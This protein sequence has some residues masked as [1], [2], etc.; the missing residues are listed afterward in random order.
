M[1]IRDRG[2]GVPPLRQVLRFLLARARHSV[3]L[4]GTGHQQAWLCD[5]YLRFRRS[6]PEPPANYGQFCQVLQELGIKAQVEIM[7]TS[8]NYVFESANA[9][10]EWW[11]RR[12]AP[13]PKDR[14]ALREA[15]LTLAEW[16]EG[17]V[18][19]YEQQRVALIHIDQAEQGMAPHVQSL[20]QASVPSSSFGPPLR[21]D[22]RQELGI[23]APWCPL[24]RGAV[25]V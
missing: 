15:L 7:N 22:P 21:F 14:P 8:A 20:D 9:L 1:C 23:L 13:A 19:I 12:I 6:L 18:G 25:T 2:A 4:M 16:R 5:L 11:A 24:T 17:T 3:I 10:V